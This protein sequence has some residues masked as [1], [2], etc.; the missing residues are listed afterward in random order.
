MACGACCVAPSIRQGFY[1][2]PE[3]KPA[4]ARCLHLD[5]ANYCTIFTDSRRPAFCDSFKA[6]PAICGDTREQAMSILQHLELIS[7]PGGVASGE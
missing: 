1:G 5:D 6:E 4:G 3:G 7:L 2:M